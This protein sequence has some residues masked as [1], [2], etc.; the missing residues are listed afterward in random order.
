M[1]IHLVLIPYASLLE[2]VVKIQEWREDSLSERGP[3]IAPDVGR[4]GQSNI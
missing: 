3:R 4:N 1:G 2:L